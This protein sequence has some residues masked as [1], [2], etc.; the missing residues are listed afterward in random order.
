MNLQFSRS[1]NKRAYSRKNKKRLE[2]KIKKVVRVVE[3][4]KKVGVKELREEE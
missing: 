2:T 3:E 1:S 4:M